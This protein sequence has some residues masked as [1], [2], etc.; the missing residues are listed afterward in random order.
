VLT[1]AQ[2]QRLA[3][4]ALKYVALTEPEAIT[5]AR[6]IGYLV[7]EG[8]P[9]SMCGP[10]SLATLQ[11]SGLIDPAANL[12]LFWQL[13]PRPGEDLGLMEATFPPE[14]YEWISLHTPINE[15]DYN[16][17]PLYP[18]DFIYLYAGS[19]GTFE[20]VLVV[21]R[22]DASG[23]AFSVTNLHTAAGYTIQEVMLYDPNQP[24]VGQFYEWTDRG[25]NYK[26][27]VTGFG[28]M[29][30]WRR[31]T[32]IIDPAQA[33]AE[34]QQSIGS[35]IQSTGGHWNIFF[36]EIGGEPFYERLAFEQTHP[37]STI[38]VPIA[39]LFF[40]ALENL[41][42][43]DVSGY[44]QSHAIQQRPM[45][46]LL[47]AMLVYSEEDATNLLTSWTVANIN[48]EKTMAG[49][50]ITHTMLTPR[51]TTPHEMALM[52]QGLYTGTMVS[53]AS[54]QIIL[55]LLNEYT[56]NDDTRLGVLRPLLGNDG[57]IYNKRGT[58]T[59]DWLIVADT[60]I[61]VYKSHAYILLVYAQPEVNQSSPS[62]EQLDAAF[63]KIAQTIWN[64]LQTGP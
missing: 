30:I 60:A 4:T 62:Y 46:E 28:G 47:R 58:M 10:L 27:G 18:G 39:M 21:S 45:N 19:S 34:L 23:R 63:P 48:F 13:D 3:G 8:H 20:H 59:T 6:S 31:S 17:H 54:R 57:M 24:G 35:I 16:Q 64:F 38:K 1:L 43:T 36:S 37:A 9:A 14:R 7:N 50:G 11:Q 32:P 51:R 49:W 42:V 41:G 52:Y 2:K 33:E 22:V 40:N 61:I 5:V 12:H 25:A 56:P 55:D 15:I 26:Y 53:P 29:D 44:I